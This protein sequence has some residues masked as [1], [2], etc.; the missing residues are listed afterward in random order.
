MWRACAADR[1]I[2]ESDLTGAIRSA[3]AVV[4]A[5]SPDSIG[6]RH[7][8]FELD[9]AVA[10]TRIRPRLFRHVADEALPP[11]WL[12]DRRSLDRA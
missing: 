4:F 3:G 1:R 12:I 10:G 9:V 8:G 11:V 2:R 6:S 5:L 7:W